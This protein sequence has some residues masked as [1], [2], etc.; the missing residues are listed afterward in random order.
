MAFAVTVDVLSVSIL[1][2][3]TASAIGKLFHPTAEFYS[4]IDR[5]PVAIELGF[6][7]QSLGFVRFGN[8]ERDA[9]GDGTFTSPKIDSQIPL[10]LQG[11]VEHE[12][13]GTDSATQD[14]FRCA[15]RDHRDFVLVL[16]QPQR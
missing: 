14:L 7:E 10:V 1:D 5:L 12:L 9:L 2:H 6:P 3:Q 11:I 16:Q 15:V 8:G 13:A 4:L